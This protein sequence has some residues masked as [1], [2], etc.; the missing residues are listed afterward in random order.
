MEETYDKRYAMKSLLLFAGFVIMVMYIET[1]LIP[2][3]P[4]ISK[5][6]NIDAAQVSLVLSMYLVSGVALNPIIGKLG[7]IYG[8]KKILVRVMIA[9][10]IA[11][12]MT[13]FA[14]SFTILLALRTIQGIGLTIF[15]LAISLIQ[16]QFPKDKVPQA[17]GIV[18]AM[19]G[20][21]AAIG[22]PI[23]SFVSNAFGW[24]TTYHT[25]V[26][27]VALFS[28]LIYFYIKES[29]YTRPNVK[30]DYKGAVGLAAF[31]ALLVFALSNGSVFGWTSPLILGLIAAALVILFFLNRFEKKIDYA[32]IDR[33]L[34]AIRN[35]LSSNL[36]VFVIGLGFFLVH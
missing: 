26:P 14:P 31:L 29:K 25:A 20:A 27:F 30:V 3:L 17:L 22:L 18:G 9:Y 16:E 12:A 5:Q 13:G 36:I 32:I 7:D 1:M 2:S 21:G 15:P 8:K 10:T 35:V 6:F 4:S 24:Q 11:V 19:F 34:L 23:G 33:K 28:I